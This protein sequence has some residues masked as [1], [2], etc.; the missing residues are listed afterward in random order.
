MLRRLQVLR[1]PDQEA[2]MLAAVPNPATLRGGVRLFLRALSAALTPSGHDADYDSLM[3]LSGLAFMLPTFA[4]GGPELDTG[5]VGELL[6]QALR[7]LGVQGT[8]LCATGPEETQIWTEPITQALRAGFGVPVLGWPEEQ[9][10][11]AVLTG[12]DPGRRVWVGWPAGY[13]EKTCLGA[14]PRACKTVVIAGTCETTAPWEAATA[15][16]EGALARRQQ[17]R[18][19]HD[20]WCQVLKREKEGTKEAAKP[21]GERLAAHVR[22]RS[23]LAD[24][25]YSAAKFVECCADLAPASALEGLEAAVDHY[26]EAARAIEWVPVPLEEELEGDDLDSAEEESNLEEAFDAVLRSESAALDSLSHALK[27]EPVRDEWSAG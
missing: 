21:L 13:E 9:D 17:M 1:E 23:W 20:T 8:V 24:A 7:A 10:D 3:G 22:L 25:R 5:D 18:A 14:P 11:W 27:G 16:F 19:A 12:V 4:D 6:P 15:S 26:E 2:V